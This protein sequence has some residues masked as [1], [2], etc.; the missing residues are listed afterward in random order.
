MNNGLGV[1]VHYTSSHHRW[2]PIENGGG[3]RFRAVSFFGEGRA[4]VLKLM[5]HF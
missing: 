3:G 1:V 4:Y 2:K 5:V